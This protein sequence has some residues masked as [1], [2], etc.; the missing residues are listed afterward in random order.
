MIDYGNGI[1]ISICPP[2]IYKENWYILSFTTY[3]GYLFTYFPIDI[4]QIDIQ[5]IKKHSYLIQPTQTSQLSVQFYWGTSIRSNNMDVNFNDFVYILW[6]INDTQTA[7]MNFN[8]VNSSFGM[9]SKFT[10]NS[11]FYIAYFDFYNSTLVYWW[12]KEKQTDLFR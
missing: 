4:S 6:R 12:G 3:Q 5:K 11:S 1:D 7:I 9:T 8:T 10:T 2:I